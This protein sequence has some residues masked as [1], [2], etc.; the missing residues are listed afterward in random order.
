MRLWSLHPQYLDPQGLVA[1]WREA[2][3]AQKVLGGETRGYRSHPQLNR[4]SAQ[5]HPLFAIG[6]YLREV[7]SE[8]VRRGYSFDQTKILQCPV[9][10]AIPVSSG[11]I[12][13]EWGHLLEKLSARNPALHEKWRVVS[14]PICHSLF[15]VV[16]GGI[17][18]WER[19]REP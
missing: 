19:K 10:S 14:S 1:L 3:L 9:H 15:R 7:H 13:Y 11:Q 18:S 8:A 4:F 12:E 16:Q 6:T 5:T 2:L 17:E